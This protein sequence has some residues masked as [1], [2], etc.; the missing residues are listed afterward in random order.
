[1][2][3]AVWIFRRIVLERAIGGAFEVLE[4]AG[5]Q[6]PEKGGEPEAVEQECRTSQASAVMAL[7]SPRA[8]PRWR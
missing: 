2:L 8:A 3:R 5:A 7:P 6:R 1:L 4:L